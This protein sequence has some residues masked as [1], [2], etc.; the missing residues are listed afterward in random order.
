MSGVLRGQGKEIVDEP[1]GFSSMMDCAF[2]FAPDMSTT[3]LEKRRRRNE[4]MGEVLYGVLYSTVLYSL[5]ELDL[6][7]VSESKTKL[8]WMNEFTTYVCKRL[9]IRGKVRVI[10]NQKLRLN[11]RSIG[12][13]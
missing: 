10:Y 13:M 12:V 5:L 4:M 9:R 11:L 7:R 8:K 6:V 1:T 2:A 3:R